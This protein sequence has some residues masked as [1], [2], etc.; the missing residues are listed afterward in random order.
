MN[1]DDDLGE[2]F[3]TTDPASLMVLRSVLDAAEISYVVQ[4]GESLWLNSWGLSGSLFNPSSICA[5]IWVRR[6]DL[7]DA[8]VLLQQ[9]PQSE[10]ED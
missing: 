6:E 10:D 1:P 4:G 2:L 9:P 3:R 5:S 7:E 8:R